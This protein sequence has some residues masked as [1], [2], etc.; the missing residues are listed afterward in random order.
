MRKIWLYGFCLGILIIFSL[1][2]ISAQSCNTKDKASS[3]KMLRSLVNELKNGKIEAA[4]KRFV[5]SEGTQKVLSEMSLKDRDVLI[6]GLKASKCFK[7]IK[8]NYLIY[9]MPFG[10]GE[11]ILQL[12]MGII[13]SESGEWIIMYW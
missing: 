3:K 13:K 5:P 2:N 4:L 7:Q 8:E 9:L 12:K 10:K 6:K 11:E 1:V